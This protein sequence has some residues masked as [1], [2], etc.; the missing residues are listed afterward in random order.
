M[1]SENAVSTKSEIATELTDAHRAWL[2]E[3]AAEQTPPLTVSGMLARLL[4]AAM[5]A[6]EE[7]TSRRAYQFSV[8]Q[9]SGYREH[10]P[11][12]PHAAADDR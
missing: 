12:Y 7:A 5:V 8:Y 6:T 10:H 3:R 11:D 4:D 2:T 9:A 1:G